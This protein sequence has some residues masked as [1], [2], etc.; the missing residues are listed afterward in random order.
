MV[1]RGDGRLR[2]N[3]KSKRRIKRDRKNGV[4]FIRLSLCSVHTLKR[5]EGVPKRDENETRHRLV[6]SWGDAGRYTVILKPPIRL[7]FRLGV[8]PPF[9]KSVYVRHNYPPLMVSSPGRKLKA[10]TK[11]AMKLGLLSE[12]LLA[13]EQLYR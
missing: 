9:F 6:L 4:L 5:N 12:F 2:W 8:A 3:R 13:T 7:A 11:W 1:G 10:V